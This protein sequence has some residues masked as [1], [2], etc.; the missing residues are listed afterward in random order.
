[1]PARSK[2]APSPPETT[3]LPLLK[4]RIRDKGPLSIADF[5]A[6]ALDHPE[7]GYYR[8][9]EPFGAAGDFVTAPEIG[10]VFGELI[11]LWLASAW[12]GVGRPA[13]FRL[14]ELGPGRGQLMADLFRAVAKM[15]GFLSAADIHLVETSERLRDVQRDRL[16]GIEITWHDRLETVPAGPLF[17]I[18]NEFFDALPVHQLIRKETD[19]AERLVTLNDDGDFA[20]IEGEAPAGLVETLDMTESPESGCIAELS[21]ARETL[22][23][24]IGERIARD[25]GV[26]LI[27]DYGA[28]VARPTGDTLQAVRGHRPVDPLSAPGETDLTTQVDFRRLGHAAADGGADV[29]G[30]VPQGT[31]LRTLG[32]EVRTA[33]LL[34]NADPRQSRDLREALFRLTD[35]GAMGEAFKVLVL[36]RPSDPP[37]PGFD[38]PSLSAE[39]YSP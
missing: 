39:R 15:P 27:V 20:F 18:A 11:G 38:A 12:R 36:S 4:A 23:R 34:K 6:L 8:R 25:G 3:L 5:M 21:P 7:Q 32:I 33:S 24:S 2:P 16:A 17:L 19:W 10:Q 28:W 29:Y 22:M 35:A 30:P 26:A 37:P 13:P 1:M 9:R 14:V 31:F